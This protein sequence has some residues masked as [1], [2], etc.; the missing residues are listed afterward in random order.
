MTKK[1]MGF[2]LFGIMIAF[3]VH[4]ATP[5]SKSYLNSKMSVIQTEIDAKMAVIQAEIDAINKRVYGD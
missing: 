1:R 2:L 3:S 4:A 5:A